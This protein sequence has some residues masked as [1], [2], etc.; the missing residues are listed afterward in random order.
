MNV[1]YFSARCNPTEHVQAIDPPRGCQASNFLRLSASPRPETLSA[2]L[3][4][5][6]RFLNLNYPK[7]MTDLTPG[8]LQNGTPRRARFSCGRESLRNPSLS[9]LLGELTS[10][11]R[12][13]QTILDVGCGCPSPLRVLQGVHLVGVDGYGPALEQARRLRSHD[14]Y[15]LRDVREIGELMRSRR[16]DACV[17]LDVIEHLEK[18]DGLRMLRSMEHLAARRVIIFTPNGFVPQQSQDGNLQEHLSGWTPEEMRA[19]GY[20][21]VGMYG[22]KRLRGQHARI[23]YTPRPFWVLVSLAAHYLHTRAHPE[24]AAAILCLK[25]V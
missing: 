12:D 17:A 7:R 11:L 14:E 25:D 15:F 22:P 5:V 9:M 23:K 10:S 24:K 21:V 16:F 18:E 13:C 2:G 4:A 6:A 19:L 8:C 1:S 3:T 20:R